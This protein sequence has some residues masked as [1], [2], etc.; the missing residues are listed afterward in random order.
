MRRCSPFTATCFCQ[1]VPG[2]AQ[3]SP[4]TVFCFLSQSIPSIGRLLFF[5]CQPPVEPR[6]TYI[7]THILSLHTQLRDPMADKLPRPTLACARIG[8]TQKQCDG[9]PQ[10]TGV[11]QGAV[12]PLDQDCDASDSRSQG[13]WLLTLDVYTTGKK[14]GRKQ[15]YSYSRQTTT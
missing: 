7:K 15:E 13:I 11:Q 8:R 9:I 10:L 5:R 14:K 1:E 2:S 6:L 12:A 4:L 3:S